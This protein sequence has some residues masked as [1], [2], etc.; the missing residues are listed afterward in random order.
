MGKDTETQSKYI[1]INPLAER[2]LLNETASI[3]SP[4]LQLSEGRQR[5]MCETTITMYI[6]VD[7]TEDITTRILPLV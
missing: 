2:S 5:R 4:W 3:F 1:S 6:I 7:C